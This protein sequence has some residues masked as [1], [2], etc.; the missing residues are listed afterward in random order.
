MMRVL[1]LSLAS[2]VSVSLGLE[3]CMNAG[4]MTLSCSTASMSTAV[5]GRWYVNGT[6]VAYVDIEKS[7]SDGLGTVTHERR[8]NITFMSL[9]LRSNGGLTGLFKCEFTFKD[10]SIF[11]SSVKHINRA[12]LHALPGCELDLKTVTW[13]SLTLATGLC[14]F[15]YGFI[16]QRMIS[17]CLTIQKSLT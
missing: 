7:K 11:T 9:T 6:I 10:L 12:Q 8:A 3:I 13:F 17:G 2:L 1:C 16:A 14:I 5:V 4:D 15:F